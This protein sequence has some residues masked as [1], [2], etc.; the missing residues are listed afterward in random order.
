M[1]EV[2]FY[3]ERNT[4]CAEVEG[5]VCFFSVAFRIRERYSLFLSY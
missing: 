1:E 2:V 5:I 4:V 3:I